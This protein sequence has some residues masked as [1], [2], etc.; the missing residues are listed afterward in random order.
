MPSRP[1][2]SPWILAALAFVVLQGCGRTPPS[3]GPSGLPRTPGASAS[4]R[5]LPSS[6]IASPSPDAT[7]SR[8]AT[9]SPGAV[10]TVG[11]DGQALPGLATYKG[12][13]SPISWDAATRS[14][15][16]ELFAAYCRPCHGAEGRGDGPVVTA[17]PDGQPRPRD[18]ASGVFK[19]GGEDW[20]VLRT[21]QEGVPLTLMMGWRI[22]KRFDEKDAWALVGFVKAMASPR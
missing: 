18:L 16:G 8:G 19:Y 6:A 15:A 3:P 22:Q 7:A 5:V 2:L 1:P 10:A 11:P 17:L 9:V 13:K 12:R 4:P 21:I 20:Q 14:R